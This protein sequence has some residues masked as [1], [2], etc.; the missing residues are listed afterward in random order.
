V[1]PLQTSIAQR[2][3][4]RLYFAHRD[5]DYYFAWITGREV[6]GGSERGECLDAA[7]K[8]VDADAASWG[9]AWRA[10]AERIE[11]QA[12]AARERGA[13]VEV[14]GAFLR[15]CTYHRAPLFM[16]RPRDPAFPDGTRR[17]QSCFQEAAALFDP[18]VERVE[19]PYRG[20]R[21]PGYFWKVD[22]TGRRRP[23]LLVVGGTETF[24]EDCYFMVGPSGPAPTGR[25]GP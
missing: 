17:M 1:D 23:T 8:V 25:S 16:T 20:Q 6:Y 3:R 5:M 7:A 13:L 15:A 22:D 18:P 9:S 2:S 19:V 14:R 21:L 11:A 4:E 24:A 10:L 12:R